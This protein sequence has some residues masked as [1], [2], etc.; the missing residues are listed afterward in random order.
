MHSPGL[1]SIVTP[2]FNQGRFLRCTI[3]SVLNQTYPHI[4]Y[5]VIDGGSTDHSVSILESYGDR[6]DWIS[7][8]D[9]GQ[10]DAINKG[11]ARCTGDIRAY[12][13]SDDV[14]LPNAVEK[15]VA[16]FEGHP[17][18]DLLYGRAHYTDAHDHITGAYRTLPFSLQRLAEDSCI[19]Q[20]ATFWRA[21]LAE[22]IGPFDAGLHY[23]MDYDYWLRAAR[24]GAKLVHVDDLLACSRLYPETKTLS[25]KEAMYRESMAVCQRHMGYVPRGPFVGLWC[26]RCDQSV[27]VGR[28]PGFA[29]F[30]ATS[31]RLLWKWRLLS[32]ARS[33]RR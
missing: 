21:E 25:G 2:S 6:F 13:N 27:G 4:E 19:C 28:W 33:K 14:L 20:P 10:A 18:W 30:M 8:R 7:E 15:A 32:R 17:D 23:C 11:F 16:Y 26:H 1:V 12:L 3:D 22:R 9:A 31:H 24:A 29:A 5:I